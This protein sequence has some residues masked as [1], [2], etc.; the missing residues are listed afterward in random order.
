[1]HRPQDTLR[2]MR[3]SMLL[4]HSS[5]LWL[6]SA[7]LAVTCLMAGGLSTGWVA[8]GLILLLSGGGMVAVHLGRKRLHR[9]PDWSPALWIGVLACLHGVLWGLQA[10]QGGFCLLLGL[11]FTGVAGLALF[12][13]WRAM[14]AAW[15]PVAILPLLLPGEIGFAEQ[16]ELHIPLAI[17]IL[18]GNWQ[19][20]R[21]GHRFIEHVFENRRLNNLLLRHQEQ[22]EDTIAQRTA[23]LRE[24]NERLHD[25]AELRTQTNQALQKSEEQL[26][27]AMTASGIG[28]WDWDIVNRRVYHSDQQRFF[29]QSM[30][31]TELVDLEH[32]VDPTDR[33]SVRDA[34]SMHLRG[35]TSY[36]HARYRVVHEGVAEP[37]WLEDSGRVIERDAK[38]RPVRMVGTRRDITAD[39][40][41]QEELRLSST[42]FNISPDGIFI[43][44]QNQRLRTCNRVFSQIVQRQKGELMGLSLFQI[45]PTEQQARIAKG[46]INNDH[47]EGEIVAARG[48]YERFPMSLKLTAIRNPDGAVSHYLGI[49]RDLTEQ[50]RHALQ[51]DYLQNYDKLTG[52]FN[53]GYFHRLLKQFEEHGPLRVNHYAVAVLNLDRFKA[54]NE[55]L[56]QDVG[57]QLLRDLAARLNNLSDPVRQVARLCSD[58]F[59][60]LIEFEGDRDVLR[61]ALSVALSEISRPCLIDDQEVVITASAGACI[62]HPGNLKQLLNQ[63]MA[64][65]NMA[66]QQGGNRVQL[67]QPSLASDPA[68]RDHLKA[69][70]QQAV[71]DGAIA[72]AYQPK[73]NLASGLIDSMEALARWKHP[74]DGW[75]DPEVF[76][77]LAEETGLIAAIGNLV[78]DRACTDV[79]GWH[80]NGLGNMSVSVNLCS[81]QT[82]D[83]ELYDRVAGVLQRS[84]LPAEYLELEVTESMLMEDLAHAE[85]Y[86]NKLRSMG[87]HLTLDDYGTGYSSLNSLK[88]FPIDA[89][90]IDRS[91]MREINDGTASPVIEAIMAMTASLKMSVVAEGVET[92]EQLNYL[93]RLG[94]DYVQGFLV[95]RPL[96]ANEIL[97]LVRHTNHRLHFDGEP[98]QLH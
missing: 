16:L 65:M 78:L 49:C 72:V 41:L 85:D 11:A 54:V 63:A 37:V 60:L 70:L 98:E 79:A 30:S 42:L 55:H 61:E 56:G 69:D 64:A 75:I 13:Q 47:W 82:Y 36:Y 7:L 86:L 12:A 31:E 17:L 94:C 27:M 93:K 50:R 52:L 5:L 73:L 9:H 25:E 2:N 1:M 81:D 26:N 19:G 96:P 71:K 38:G 57:D 90:K 91:F 21:I 67:Y 32:R 3:H 45:L 51:V 39:M 80:R 34:L 24:S 29:G 59:A 62:V 74:Q 76:I 68:E 6:S 97:P 23:E 15:T 44:D 18:L 89:L 66:R 35:R 48:A 43:L 33:S 22:L 83:E 53:R 87:V 92:R 77:P 58:E 95:S 14:F 28:F 10:R 46:V 4:R 84:G 88:R 40:R 8:T 20:H